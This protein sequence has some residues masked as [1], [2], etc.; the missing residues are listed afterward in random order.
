MFC[1]QTRHYLLTQNLLNNEFCTTWFNLVNPKEKHFLYFYTATS[2]WQ[3]VAL[4][5]VIL[6]PAEIFK[7]SQPKNSH[8]YVL[9]IQGFKFKIY[10][11]H[12]KCLR[13]IPKCLLS[14]SKKNAS[15]TPG[16]CHQ[17]KTG[18]HRG[19]TDLSQSVRLCVPQV[20]YPHA[21]QWVDINKAKP[22]PMIFLC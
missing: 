16:L 9:V 11:D 4:F 3:R 8:I 1:I 22:L 15:Y 17:Y 10:M 5:N 6:M 19:T 18:S 21:Q 20:V 2:C 12:N 7:K 13:N 14:T